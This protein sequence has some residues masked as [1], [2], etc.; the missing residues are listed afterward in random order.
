VLTT[1]LI[2]TSRFSLAGAYSFLCSSA[3]S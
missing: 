3:P 2:L 1:P